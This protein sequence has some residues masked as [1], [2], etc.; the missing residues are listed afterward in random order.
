MKLKQYIKSAKVDRK[1]FEKICSQGYLSK[2]INGKKTPSIA[3]AKKI[4]R[5]T[6]GLVSLEDW[7]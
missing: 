7:G 4:R 3:M 5:K 6:K 2:L 1:D